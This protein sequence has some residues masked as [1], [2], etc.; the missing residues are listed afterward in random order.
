M[1][2]ENAGSAEINYAI[3]FNHTDYLTHTVKFRAGAVINQI[4]GPEIVR[5][6][7]V[8]R[9]NHRKSVES[10]WQFFSQLGHDE[11]D[12]IYSSLLESVI[13]RKVAETT[14]IRNH[15]AS[16]GKREA[17]RPGHSMQLMPSP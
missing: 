5:R 17:T 12:T 3:G 1:D 10:V 14:S 13:L 11:K 4:A 6:P 2:A 7:A 15:S 9:I 8:K 16:A